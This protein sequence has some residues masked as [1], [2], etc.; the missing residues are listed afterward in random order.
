M[1]QILIGHRT[2]CRT[3]SHF[4]SSLPTSLRREGGVYSTLDREINCLP[5]EGSVKLE[6]FLPFCAWWCIGVAVNGGS[7][8]RVSH[9]Q[10]SFPIPCPKC[11]TQWINKFALSKLTF[12]ILSALL[13]INVE[14]FPNLVVESNV[15]FNALYF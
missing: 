9:R 4:C 6:L 11:F 8:T 12:N 5:S 7:L 3:R 10:M 1:S 13:T 2:V 15:Y 14:A